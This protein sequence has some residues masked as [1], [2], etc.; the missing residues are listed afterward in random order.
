MLNKIST[1][2]RQWLHLRRWPL[3]AERQAASRGVIVL[4]H[5]LGEHLGRYVTLANYLNQIGW[6]V[7]GCDQRGH[8]V[9]EGP[10]GFIAERHDLLHDLSLVLDA[11][12]DDYPGPRVL[13][14][15]SM[16][17][18]VAARFVAE[19][20]AAQPALWSRSVDGLVLSSP[21]LD[22]GLR[23]M[24]RLLLA[25]LGRMAPGASRSNGLKPKWISRHRA[26]VSGY[27]RDRLVHDRICPRLARFIV[28]AGRHVR[29]C[30]PQWQ[31]P[32]LLMWAGADRCV[33]PRGSSA[34]AEAAP[35]HVVQS[36]VF[37]GLYH[38]IFNEPERAEVV[39]QLAHWL[40]RFDQA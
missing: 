15:H 39:A 37:P 5:G 36:Q 27:Q 9:S 26:I 22:P 6:N 7:I 18:V 20:M 21:A 8:G 16:G 38:E 17:G 29:A 11:T 13:L 12:R 28:D 25:T 14:G 30:A 23:F 2:D 10:R 31:M 19:A 1:D 34:F 3:P 24:Q 32:T 40:R 35:D 33:A 4:V